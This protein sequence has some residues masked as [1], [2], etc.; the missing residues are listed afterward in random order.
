MSASHQFAAGSILRS[1]RMAGST[2]RTAA[3]ES[4]SECPVMGCTGCFTQQVMLSLVH[5]HI[6]EVAWRRLNLMS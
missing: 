6:G 3:F 2:G 4:M 5:L 1:Q